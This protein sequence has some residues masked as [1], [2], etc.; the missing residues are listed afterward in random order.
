MC[1]LVKTSHEEEHKYN[2]EHTGL[3]IL[4]NV[5]FCGQML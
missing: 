3:S 2:L 1:L 4:F 5:F